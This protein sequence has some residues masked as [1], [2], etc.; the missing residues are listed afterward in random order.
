MNGWIAAMNILTGVAIGLTIAGVGW[1][2]YWLT[3]FELPEVL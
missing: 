3:H 2:F 1:I